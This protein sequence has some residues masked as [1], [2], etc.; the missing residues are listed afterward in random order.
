[1][2]SLKKKSILKSIAFFC[3]T[4]IVLVY[5]PVLDSAVVEK[6]LARIEGKIFTLSDIEIAR[7][8]L[9]VEITFETIDRENESVYLNAL[10][11]TELIYRECMLL[12]IVDV[13]DDEVENRYEYLKKSLGKSFKTKLHKLEISEDHLKKLI[14]EKLYTKKYYDLREDFFIGFGEEEGKTKMEEWIKS[15]REK[16]ELKIIGGVSN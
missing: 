11:D 15:L 5:P 4:Y 14:E 6:I 7:S 13:I 10:I 16:A 3:L 9:L 1:M 12:K 8:F 2:G